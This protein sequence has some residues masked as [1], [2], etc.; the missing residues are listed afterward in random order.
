MCPEEHWVGAND[1]YVV[2]CP[3]K[4]GSITEPF[5]AILFGKGQSVLL[6]CPLQL[7]NKR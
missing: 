4:Q 2:C 5:F 6:W 3:S 7:Q 1:S